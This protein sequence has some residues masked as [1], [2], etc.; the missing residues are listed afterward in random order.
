MRKYGLVPTPGSIAS[1]ASAGANARAW[2]YRD[3][4]QDTPMPATQLVS[5]PDPDEDADLLR[6]VDAMQEDEYW[7]RTFWC[8]RYYRQGLDYE[9][10]A[11][12]YCAGYIGYAQYGGEYDD[13]ESSLCANW[14]RIKGDSRVT[15][16]DARRAMRAAWDRMAGQSEIS[17][18]RLRR[19]RPRPAA[20]AMRAAP[21]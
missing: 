13:A 21:G 14:Q 5:A 16:E 10:Y 3:F 2:A 15:L 11:P 12:A 9:D 1:Y 20:Q 6:A 7:R 17:L 18:G 19:P 8:E 4:E